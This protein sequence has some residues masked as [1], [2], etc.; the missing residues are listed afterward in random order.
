M[1]AHAVLAH[2]HPGQAGPLRDNSAIAR[3]QHRL[4]FL[5]TPQRD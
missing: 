2:L 5:A 3:L 4:G 1:A